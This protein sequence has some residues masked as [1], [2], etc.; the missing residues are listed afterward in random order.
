MQAI[1]TK[2]TD[3]CKSKYPLIIAVAF[4]SRLSYS[5]FTS[6]FD[7]S[8]CRQQVTLN[9]VMSQV[10]NRNSQKATWSLSFSAL[11]VVGFG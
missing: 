6:T 3:I 8:K 2:D 1:L 5:T 11:S 7:L 10:N 4:P 9:G